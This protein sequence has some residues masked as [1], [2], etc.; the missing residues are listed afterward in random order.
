MNIDTTKLVRA[1]D[2]YCPYILTLD[3]SMNY[4]N[5]VYDVIKMTVSDLKA[6]GW[7]DT[8]IKLELD[9]MIE[10]CMKKS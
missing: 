2:K 4:L 8:K 6:H 7:D 3:P 10:S 9:T 5:D 1:I